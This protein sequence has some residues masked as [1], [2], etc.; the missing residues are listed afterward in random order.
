LSH[1]R[2]GILPRVVQVPF[3]L[4]S[5]RSVMTT[6]TTQAMTAEQLAR[7]PD[8]GK[9]YELVEGEVRMMPPAENEHGMVTARL[10]WRVAQHVEERNL[11]ALFAAETGFLLARAPDTVRAPDLAFVTRERLEQVG[12]VEGFWPGAPDLVA[13]VVSP[14]DSFSDVEEKALAWLNAG[15]QVVWGVDPKQRQVTVYRSRDDIAVFQSGARLE[16]PRLLPGWSLRV[17]ELFAG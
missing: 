10:T 5:D 3:S 4:H 15:T 7:I 16:E 9:R 12:S 1:G 14:G 8:D 17:A 6:T 2:C 11:G 13:E